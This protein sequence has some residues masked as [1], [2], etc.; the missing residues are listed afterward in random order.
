MSPEVTRRRTR[1]LVRVSVTLVTLV[2][3]AVGVLGFAAFGWSRMDTECRHPD[4]VPAGSTAAAVEFSWSWDPLGFTCT[5]PVQ[6]S[7]DVS[8]TKLWW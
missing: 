8:V 7:R 5:W 3:V 1:A 2:A 4:L 6:D